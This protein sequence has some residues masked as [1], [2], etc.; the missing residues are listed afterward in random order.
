MSFMEELAKEI[1]LEDFPK[2]SVLELIAQH[3]ISLAL[4]V[5]S[6]FDGERVYI[7]KFKETTKEAQNRIVSRETALIRATP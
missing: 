7:H 2:G 6:V 5:S 1:T 3:D 4:T